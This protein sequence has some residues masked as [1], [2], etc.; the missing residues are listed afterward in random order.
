MLA[1]LP[2]IALVFLIGIFNYYHQDWRKSFLSGSVVLGV[3]LTILTEVLSLFNS[4]SFGHIIAAWSSISLLLD[5]F[6][7]VCYKKIGL[8]LIH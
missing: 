4:L 8:N 2:I 1:L 6:M 3:I 5:G 7:F